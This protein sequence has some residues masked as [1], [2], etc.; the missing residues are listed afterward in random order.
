MDFLPDGSF[1]VFFFQWSKECVRYME[2]KNRIVYAIRDI[3][4][5]N[6]Y[7]FLFISYSK[8]TDEMK[9]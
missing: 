4:F 8:T 3:S 2:E 6:R 1:L 7:S 9:Y 5:H